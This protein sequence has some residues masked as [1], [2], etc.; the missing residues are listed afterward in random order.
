MTRFTLAKTVLKIT[1]PERLTDAQAEEILEDFDI[2]QES[3][4]QYA[5]DLME[6]FA[7]KYDLSVEVE[8]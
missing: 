6:S 5:R 2:H 7:L 3:V 8:E 4:A 1:A